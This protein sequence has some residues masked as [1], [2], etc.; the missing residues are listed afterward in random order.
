MA[1]SYIRDVMMAYN[2]S[3]NKNLGRSV[4][5]TKYLKTAVV[6]MP[7]SRRDVGLKT[8]SV[9]CRICREHRRKKQGEKLVSCIG[10]KILP[11][12]LH[13]L[14]CIADRIVQN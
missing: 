13:L 6:R 8:Y 9:V 10:S 12:T 5:G 2:V 3:S 11:P 14:L 4:F 7:E 1:D